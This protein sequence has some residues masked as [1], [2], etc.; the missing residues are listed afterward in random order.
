MD[1]GVEQDVAGD[2]LSATDVGY[3]CEFGGK[4]EGRLE[5]SGVWICTVLAFGSVAANKL[6]LSFVFG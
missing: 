4:L 6:G 1:G 2:V 5:S 3:G